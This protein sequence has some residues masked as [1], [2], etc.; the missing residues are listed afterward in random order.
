MGRRNGRPPGRTV[1][2]GYGED[3]R[4]LR[5]KFDRQIKVG[6]MP[7]CARCGKAIYPGQEWH[8]D[9]SDDRSG[10]LGPSHARC[11]LEAAGRKGSRRPELEVEVRERP[12]GYF[13]DAAG[14]LYRVDGH[15]NYVRVS[16]AR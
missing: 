7:P 1:G 11:N 10:W 16:K 15:S 13:E 2:A 5:K 9:H 8:L 12:D 14:R 6:W 3:H 4:R